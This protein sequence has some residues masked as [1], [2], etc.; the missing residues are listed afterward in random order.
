MIIIHGN[1]FIVPM[2][3]RFRNHWWS[4]KITQLANT[5]THTRTQ[6]H[7]LCEPT[8]DGKPHLMNQTANY[9][10]HLI[11]LTQPTAIAFYFWKLWK[12][13]ML[14]IIRKAWMDGYGFRVIPCKWNRVCLAQSHNN[15]A[16]E[17]KI[18]SKLH[19]YVFDIWNK[20]EKRPKYVEN[21]RCGCG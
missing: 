4:R 9:P 8:T 14:S 17:C 16:I 5:Q 15:K 7:L 10:L 2:K 21:V 6:R 12:P 19:S 18:Q 20:C 3:L 13:K 11:T 1:Q